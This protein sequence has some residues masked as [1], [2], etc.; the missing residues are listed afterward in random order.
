MRSQVA[1]FV[2]AIVFGAETSAAHAQLLPRRDLSYSIAKTIAETAI[3]S[4][5]AGGYRVSAVVV[6]HGET[7]AALRGDNASPHAMENARRK[8][9]TA[10]SFRTSTTAYAKRLA[11]G[12]PVVREQVTLPNVIAIPG[13]LPIKAGDDFMGGV[14]LSGSPGLD[15]PASRRVWTRSP[16]SSSEVPAAAAISCQ[17][18]TGRVSGE[19]LN[20]LDLLYSLRPSTLSIGLSRPTRCWRTTAICA[21]P[22]KTGVDVTPSAP[23]VDLVDRLTSRS[24][25]PKGRVVRTDGGQRDRLTELRAT[26][27]LELDMGGVGRKASVQ[28]AQLGL[29]CRE[30]RE[31]QQFLL[32]PLRSRRRS[33]VALPHSPIPGHR[34]LFRLGPR[35]VSVWRGR[36]RRR[37]LEMRGQAGANA[38]VR[39]RQCHADP[40]QGPAQTQGL[41]LRDRP[42]INDAQSASRSGSPRRDHHAR[43]AVGRNQV[44]IGISPRTILE[45]RRPN[46]SFQRRAM[47]KGGGRRRGHCCMGHPVGRLRFQLSRPTRSLPRQVPNEKQAAESVDIGKKIP[48]LIRYETC[49]RIA[50]D[51]A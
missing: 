25:W 6:D 46:S 43:D 44:R 51:G 35:A 20:E 17:T 48:P 28:H 8:A 37:H 26:D 47:P 1:M 29:D 36:L 11:D 32:R 38:A 22:P 42:A 19:E 18:A 13:G 41:G 34:R 15:E 4:C 5:T 50:V 10:L 14:R 45:D 24:R 30:P 2:F 7:I 23:R 16:I 3:E 40:L 21:F 33:A 12:D 49:A 39:G 9:Y 31:R 27:R